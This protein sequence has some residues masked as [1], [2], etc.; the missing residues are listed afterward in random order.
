MQNEKGLAKSSEFLGFLG[1]DVEATIDFGKDVE[2]SKITLHTLNQNGS[3][4]YLPSQIQV[5]F[6]TYIDTGAFT[7]L[8]PIEIITQQVTNESNVQI[9]KLDKPKT[10]R[11]IKL[12]AKNYGTIPSGKP[13][14]GNPAWLFIDEIEVE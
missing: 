6:I 3:W 11:S 10:C 2:I 7:R 4:I 8:P 13:G 14:A 5:A 9:I 12:F 1:K